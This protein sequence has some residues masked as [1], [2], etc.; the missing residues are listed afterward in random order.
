M[1]YAL[2]KFL[3]VS[4]ENTFVIYLF[5][6]TE[7]KKEKHIFCIFAQNEPMIIYKNCHA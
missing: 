7:S 6:A 2:L 4:G 3:V 5:V 1:N